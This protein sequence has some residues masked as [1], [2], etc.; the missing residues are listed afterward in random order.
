MA[1]ILDE[2]QTLDTFK[3]GYA[4]TKKIFGK[5]EVCIL[6]GE[7]LIPLDRMPR[8]QIVDA[9]MRINKP[10][11]KT[12]GNLS[13]IIMIQKKCVDYLQDLHKI[14]TDHIRG[15]KKTIKTMH[16]RGQSM[17]EKPVGG[18]EAL[19]INEPS[20]STNA[21]RA[22]GQTDYTREF[23]ARAEHFAARMERQEEPAGLDL[24]DRK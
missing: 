4:Q 23:L 18:I 21:K 22:I 12:K 7:K 9:D 20:E 13:T 2:K 15:K 24:I 17:A 10:R 11:D 19:L 16:Q 3:K 14:E 5:N 1:R 8:M 6:P